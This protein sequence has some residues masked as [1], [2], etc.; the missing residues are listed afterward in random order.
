MHHLQRYVTRFG[1]F[2]ML[3]STFAMLLLVMKTLEDEAVYCDIA[4]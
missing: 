2:A 1:I 4:T 3:L